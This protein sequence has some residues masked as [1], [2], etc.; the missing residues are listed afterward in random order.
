MAHERRPRPPVVAFDVVGTLF[1]LD[2]VGR[3]LSDAGL[4]EGAL[5]EWFGR[6]L[7]DA[8]ALDRVGRYVPFRDVA[9]GT[10]EV[11]LAEQGQGPEKAAGVLQA[12]AELPAHPDVRPAFGQ[13]RSA[14]I[15]IIAL[16]NGGADTT[17]R[18]LA[19]AG[20]VD[21][22]ERTISIDEVRHWKPHREV[23]R[24]AARVVGVTATTLA[25]VAAHAWDILGASRAGLT[26]GWVS[27]EEK[28]FHPAMAEPTVHGDTLPEVVAGLLALKA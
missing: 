8:F 12:F 14:G 3:R 9:R 6:F 11:M 23:Y 19:K 20:L 24:H 28:L 5:N 16:T 10:L 15:R 26:T 1:S 21:F 25:L 17:Q 22:V 2:P 27:R 13:L 18:L 7:R 4:R